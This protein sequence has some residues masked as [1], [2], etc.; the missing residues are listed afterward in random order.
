MDMLGTGMVLAGMPLIFFAKRRD[1]DDSDRGD[2][3]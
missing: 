2:K 3:P 1:K